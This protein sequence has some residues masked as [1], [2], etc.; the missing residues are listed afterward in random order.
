M[1]QVVD[2][3][4]IDLP[5]L[6]REISTD[7]DTLRRELREARDEEQ[8]GDLSTTE[9]RRAELFLERF[10]ADVEGTGASLLSIYSERFEADGDE[11]AGQLLATCAVS[12][13]DKAALGTNTSLTAEVVLAAMALEP[14]EDDTGA[15]TSNL[16]PAAI[17]GLRVGPAVRVV[18]L[19]EQRL[20]IT[21]QLR[22]FV[23]T[24]FV[25]VPDQ[26]D[27]LVVAQFSTLNVEDSREFSE[28]FR[29][30]ADTI[31]FYREGDPTEL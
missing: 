26:F 30:L 29:A 24:F 4:R 9:R 28:L 25:P 10:I 14:G 3:I 2:S 5:S 13:L 31:R 8:W 17:V 7:P 18:R 15:V 19:V 20:S 27:Q 1:T 21:E 23:E 6:W 16:E 12:V 22:V 11:P